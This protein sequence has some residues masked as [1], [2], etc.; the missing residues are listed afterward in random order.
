MNDPEWLTHQ[1]VHQARLRYESGEP[2]QPAQRRRYPDTAYAVTTCPRKVS[3]LHATLNALDRAG[4]DEP[5][6]I[7]DQH[8]RRGAAGNW[9]VALTDLYIQQPNAQRYAIFQDDIDVR[10]H[11]RAVV[12]A[13]EMPPRAGVLS[14]YVPAKYTA[15]TSGVHRHDKLIGALA[16][17]LPAGPVRELLASGMLAS[18]RATGPNDGRYLDVKLGE[19]MQEQ[20]YAIYYYHPSLVQHTG[21]HSTL[22]PNVGATISNNRRSAEYDN[23]PPPARHH[24]DTRNADTKPSPKSFLK[25]R[26]GQ[27]ATPAP[28]TDRE[29]PQ[30][31]PEHKPAADLNLGLF[32][33][34]TASGLGYLTRDLFRQLGPRRWM[35]PRHNRFPSLDPPTGAE[36]L[37]CSSCRAGRFVHGLDAVIFPEAPLRTELAKK[38]K[39]AGAAVVCIPMLEWL[40][41]HDEWMQFVD[42][43][44][45]P[46]Q[47]S[48]EV[49]QHLPGIAAH[50]PYPIDPARFPFRPRKTLETYVYVAGMHSPRKQSDAMAAAAYI[51]TDIPLIVYEQRRSIAWP[52]HVDVRG[53]ADNAELYQDGDALL[54]PSAWEGLGLPLLEAQAAGMPVIATHGAPMREANPWQTIPCSPY[55]VHNLGRPTTGYRIDPRDLADAMDVNHGADIEKASYAAHKYIDGQ[56]SWCAQ[57]DA[58]VSFL[59]RAVAHAR[60]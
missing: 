55:D 28:A 1:H 38:A 10:A 43:W 20:D 47:Q 41:V 36:I 49:C 58:I 52:P 29:A 60:A 14:L 22:Y 6:I 19:W 54:L 53:A 50:I 57:R 11:A 45:C 31:R 9:L 39:D 2:A 40:P 48:Y 16:L 44:L 34:N 59:R 56:R 13:L 51:A 23:L 15:R 25:R 42:G 21:E 24:A 27:H 3:T 12:D 33:Y 17:I 46:T 8:K 32:G 5:L 4:W 7:D 18:Y 35:I 37:E 30:L 26:N